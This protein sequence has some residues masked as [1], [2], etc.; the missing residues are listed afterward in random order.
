MSETTIVVSSPSRLHFGLL[1]F[2]RPHD[3]EF[4]GAGVMIHPPGLRLRF[5]PGE[6]FA[7]DGPL[8]D[9]VATFARR[10]SE[11][12]GRS[13]AA[14]RIVAESMPPQHA[15]LGVGTQLGLCVAAG[16]YAALLEE[17]PPA[18][19]LAASVGRGLRSAVGT[20]GFEQGGLI[21]ER[22]KGPGDKLGRL[23]RRIPL[24]DDWR[25]VLIREPHRQGLA[26]DS[27]RAAFSTLPPVPAE[28][29][30]RLERLLLED[31]APA[32]EQADFARF[33]QTLHTYGREAGLCFA[34][35]QQGAYNGPRV[36]QRV[37]TLRRLGIA[38]V[39]Q[40]SWGPTVF[41]L[42]ENQAAAEQLV[43]ALQ[44]TEPDPTVEYDIAAVS[45]AGGSVATTSQSLPG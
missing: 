18:E 41:A 1:G 34:P 15:G 6:S 13:L 5:E 36:A 11:H 10:W 44:S 38:G 25:F 19:Q 30:A 43:A 45:N 3:R 31:L 23:A 20:H 39:G 17:S 42:V 12:T 32:A 27:E 33:S 8:A 4:G 40:S 28:T 9:R 29:T 26:G 22:G 16:L 24:P 35:L 14:V 7:A 37:Q 2:G 21:I